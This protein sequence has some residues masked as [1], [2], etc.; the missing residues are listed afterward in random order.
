MSGKGSIEQVQQPR[1]HKGKL[2]RVSRDSTERKLA[3]DAIKESE[4]KFRQIFENA[5][6]AMIYLDKLGT[7]LDVN[8]VAVEIFGGSREELEGKHFTKVGLFSARDIPKLMLNFKNILAGKDLHVDIVVRNKKGRD[9]PL[10]CKASLLKTDG[11]ITGVMVIA[12]DITERKRMDQ[13]MRESVERY[14][15]IFE[16]AADSIVLIDPETGEMIQF[17]DKAHENLGYSREEFQKL[18]IPNFEIIESA[19]EVA[20]HIDKIVREGADTFETKHITKDGQIRDILVS[21]KAISIGGKNFCQSIWRDITERKKAEEEILDYQTRLKSLASELLLAGERERRRIAIGVHDQI[22]QQLA[23][24]KLELQ[25]LGALVSN[26]SVC[27]SLDKA[28]GLM[29]QIIGDAR[30][31]TFELSNPVLYEIGL[32][33]AVESWLG[34]HIQKDSGLKYKLFSEPDPLKPE[35][36]TSVVLFGIIREL[37][38]NIVKHADANMVQVHIQESGQTIQVSIEDDGVGFEWPKP[39]SPIGETGGF[40]LFNARE[41]V[42]YLGGS[43]EIKSKPGEGTCVQISV[44]VKQGVNR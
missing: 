40:G 36:G 30:S 24:L 13:G 39:D 31:L 37:L 28:Y 26:T 22:G 20:K 6:D 8:N 25:S 38:T 15:A 43:F 3:A 18:K 42:E 1:V 19:D 41:R 23:L 21:S 12:R 34:Q 44:P 29:D 16:Q 27:S 9:I 11:K 14:R 32:D 10:E 5:N 2:E 7:V 35:V 4:R 17:N 33:A